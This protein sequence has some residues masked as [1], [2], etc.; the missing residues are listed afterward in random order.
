M[1]NIKSIINKHNK[2]VLDPPTNTTERTCNCI[3][4]WKC[5]LQKKGLANNIMYK[6]TLKSNQDTYQHKIY[7]GITKPKFK[8][9]YANYIKSFRQR[10]I[11]VTLNSQMNYGVLKATTTLQISSGKYLENISNIT[12]TPKGG[13]CVWTKLLK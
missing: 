9:R 4:K 6:T 8:Q 3:N 5:P 12:L 7:Y 13:P 11:N 2:S 1:P 10:N